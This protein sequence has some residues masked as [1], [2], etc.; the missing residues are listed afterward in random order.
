MC[1]ARTLLLLLNS[2]THL[3]TTV[4]ETYL[5]TILTEAN[6]YIKTKTA[7]T[8]DWVIYLNYTDLQLSPTPATYDNKIIMSLVDI[9]QEDNNHNPQKYVQQGNHYVLRAVPMNFYIY[10]LFATNFKGEQALA[11]LRYLSSIIACFQSKN[12]FTTQNTPSMQVDGIGEFPISLVKLDYQE[13]SAL[14]SSLQATYTPSVL[15]KVGMVPVADTPT[16]LWPEV[17]AI[18]DITL[19][20][21]PR[22]S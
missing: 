9:Q 17:P 19:H 15:Y 6:S 3:A 10:L 14:W 13:K 20:T 7:S 18:S 16:M 4:L 11:G 22:I 21:S 1:Y 2:T 8:E 5:Q 12:T